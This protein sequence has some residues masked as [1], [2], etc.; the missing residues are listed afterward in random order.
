MIPKIVHQ[1]WVGPCRPP[2]QLIATW[3]QMAAEFGWEH[4]LW[5]D[6]DID[7]FGLQNKAICDVEDWTAKCD[8]ARH[9]ILLRHGG[10]YADCDFQWEPGVD[11]AK[12]LNFDQA[13]F[14]LTTEQDLRW[15]K[16]GFVDHKG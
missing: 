11:I 2:T 16:M 5:R 6:A 7:E 1:I 13:E 10:M 9:E 8:V 4:K 14:C 12:A 15:A 3:Q